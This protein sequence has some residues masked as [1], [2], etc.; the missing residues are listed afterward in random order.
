VIAARK[1]L[2]AGV[3]AKIWDALRAAT[4]SDDGRKLLSAVFGGEGL[5]NGLA[6][7]YDSLS[8]ALEM[9]AKRGLFD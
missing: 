5:Q 3:Q 6:K 9:A 1:T 4:E 7:S 8:R 2:A